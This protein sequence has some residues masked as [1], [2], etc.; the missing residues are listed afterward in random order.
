MSGSLFKV[1]D[2]KFLGLTYII[3][4]VG[5]I[6][7]LFLFVIMMT[8]SGRSP[9]IKINPRLIN[10]NDNSFQEVYNYGNN[11]GLIRLDLFLLLI[12]TLL[13]FY[14][15]YDN[16]YQ[17]NPIEN[18]PTISHYYINSFS[19]EFLT[20]TDIESFGY[21]LFLSYPIITV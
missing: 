19:S 9:N 12:F 13:L 6:S 21:V 11:S 18:S 7:I 1:M 20:F 5:A 14:M 16:L 10:S 2:L 15:G 8:E 4:Y 17:G 3:V